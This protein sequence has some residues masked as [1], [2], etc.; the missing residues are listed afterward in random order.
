V[1]PRNL[2]EYLGGN[3]VVAA[4]L[5]GRA[6]SPGL[7]RRPAGKVLARIPVGEDVPRGVSGGVEGRDRHE[8]DEDD[9]TGEGERRVVEKKAA[10]QAARAPLDRES[11]G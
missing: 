11:A 2:L 5:L 8:Q 1:L 7:T 6:V 9:G 4:L 10:A 3:F